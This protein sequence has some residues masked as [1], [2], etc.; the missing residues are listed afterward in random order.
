MAS[1]IPRAHRK[2]YVP[3]N[4]RTTTATHVRFGWLRRLLSKWLRISIRLPRLLFQ[5]PRACLSL[6]RTS[7][8]IPFLRRAKDDP[9]KSSEA[10]WQQ[11]Q[12]EVAA[13]EALME[14]AR[15]N[16]GDPQQLTAMRDTLSLAGDLPP[17]AWIHADVC[18]R[19]QTFLAG[20]TDL[21]EKLTSVASAATNAVSSSQRLACC[22]E[23]SAKGLDDRSAWH[24][25]YLQ[26][27]NDCLQEVA[28]ADAIA[29]KAATRRASFV[30][31]TP[32]AQSIVRFFAELQR[33]R[34]RSA[35]LTIKSD[36]Y[37]QQ[38]VEAVSLCLRVID[39]LAP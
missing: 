36:A 21:F 32:E 6:V 20:Q 28:A 30:G 23:R 24:A 29:K 16:F 33:H 22:Y 14:S 34:E 15:R 12:I 37:R 39:S 10:N 13:V 26:L 8:R 31:L 9:A 25:G 1:F 3:P 5:I 27:A 4:Q 11:L 2:L 35:S 17:T 19:L 18:R 38:L 7:I